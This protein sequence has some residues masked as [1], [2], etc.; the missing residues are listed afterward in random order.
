MASFSFPVAVRAIGQAEVA[1]A[2]RRAHAEAEVRNVAELLA[3]AE[4]EVQVLQALQ[5][6]HAAAEICDVRKLLA[7][8]LALHVNG[9]A[10]NY[11]FF[12]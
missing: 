1:V 8:Q 5:I 10:Y 9:L 11:I 12:F 4:V 3:S 7:P 6:R 2:A